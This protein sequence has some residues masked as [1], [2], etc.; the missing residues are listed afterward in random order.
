MGSWK[1][2]T[3]RTADPDPPARSSCTVTHLASGKTG[4]AEGERVDVTV[5]EEQAWAELL[6]QLTPRVA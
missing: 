3:Y 2:S 6:E 5:V 4:H 1:V